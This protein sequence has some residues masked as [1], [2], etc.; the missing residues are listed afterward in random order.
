MDIF[1]LL[2]GSKLVFD[3][4]ISPDEIDYTEDG[5]VGVY[6]CSNENTCNAIFYIIDLE[7]DTINADDIY[8]YR[9]IK[10]T[11]LNDLDL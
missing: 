8:D 7:S 2:C 3:N 6:H 1:C 10:Y 11:F 4:E 5:I 9:T